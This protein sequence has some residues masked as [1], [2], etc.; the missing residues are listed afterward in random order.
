MIGHKPSPPES[1]NAIAHT[2]CPDWE[3]VSD[4]IRCP[5]CEYDLRGLSEPRCPECGYSFRWEEI[6]DRTRRRHDYLFEHHPEN[7]IRAFIKTLVGGL[8]PWRFWTSLHPMQ[9]P[10][11]RRLWQYRSIVLAS[12]WLPLAVAIATTLIR[13]A[14]G[15]GVPAVRPGAWMYRPSWAEGRFLQ[16]WALFA[17]KSNYLSALIEP[18][19]RSTIPAFIVMMTFLLLA[20]PALTVVPLT[21][22][23][24]TLRQAKVEHHHV[25][26]CIIYSFDF[27]V[28][29]AVWI[30]ALATSMFFMP[31]WLYRIATTVMDWSLVLM[32]PLVWLVMMIR[33]AF[34][35]RSYLRLK[36][37]LAV[38]LACEIIVLLLIAVLIMFVGQQLVRG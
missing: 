33:L 10:D 20:L 18:I 9:R 21:I 35:C 6:L 4:Q 34:A 29:L 31:P 36:H 27:V 25:Q 37:A 3:T 14:S 7:N 30:A 2:A 8:L 17:G 12:V 16:M 13:R 38:V 22:F 5:M 1:E 23:Q 28:W 24:S 11:L 32:F 26:R 19:L 15:S